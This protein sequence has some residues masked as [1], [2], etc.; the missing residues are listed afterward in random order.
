MLYKQW[1]IMEEKH[2]DEAQIKKLKDLQPKMV[3]KQK[4]IVMENEED[5]E[6]AGFEEYYEYIF[7][8]DKQNQKVL[9]ILE[10]A[11]A[12]KKQEASKEAK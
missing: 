9:K 8:D 1:L 5:E 12:W 3:K 6:E 11:K 7:K 10:K 2:G 4:K